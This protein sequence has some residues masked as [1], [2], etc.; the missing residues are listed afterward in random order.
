MP[1]IQHR[2]QLYSTQAGAASSQMISQ[3]RPSDLNPSGPLRPFGLNLSVGHRMEARTRL[4]TDRRIEEISGRNWSCASVAARQNQT[5]DVTEV[6][7][8]GYNGQEPPRD[9]V[10]HMLGRTTGLGMS[11]RREAGGRNRSGKMNDSR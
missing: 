6:L 10:E 9:L 3:L 8:A 5:R 2:S 4:G 7:E 11:A 1:A